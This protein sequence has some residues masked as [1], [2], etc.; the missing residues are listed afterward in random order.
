[1]SQLA[2]EPIMVDLRRFADAF[3]TEEEI[4]RVRAELPETDGE[5]ME[6]P[7]HRAAISLLVEV[8]VWYLRGRT[9]FYVGGNMFL[10]FSRTQAKKRDEYKGPDFFFVKGVDGARPRKIWWVFDEDNRFPDVIMELLSPTTATE[11]RT[12]KKDLYEKTFRTP[13]YFWFDPEKNELA[14]WRLVGG[15][16]KAVVPNERGWLWSEEL[17]LWIGTWEG[18]FQNVSGTWIRFYDSDGNLL[19]TEAEAQRERA[20]EE[21]QRADK[22]AAELARVQALLKGKETS[23]DQGT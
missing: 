2:G 4:D 23:T 9:D 22:L 13:E 17:G 20:D 11:D 3:L 8:I 21:R 15:V 18:T 5:P 19:P 1:M 7:W 16:Y 6:S 12:T 14:G 10:Y